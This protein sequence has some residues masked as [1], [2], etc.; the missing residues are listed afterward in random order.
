MNTMRFTRI[1]LHNW[2]N[3]VRVDVPLARRVLVIGP[4]AS[5]KSNFLDAFRFLR[6]LTLPSG[7]G[8]AAAVDGLRSG[9]GKLRS[10]HARGI[11]SDIMIRV[12]VR[13]DSGMGWFYELAFTQ[14]SGA[15]GVPM[16][17]REI[18]ARLTKEGRVDPPLLNRPDD[19]DKADRKRLIQ[20]AVEQVNANEK[21]RELNEFFASVSYLH[22]VPQLL[23]EGQAASPNRIGA[24][25]YG[26]DLLDRMGDTSRKTREARLRR[27]RDVLKAVT[28]DLEELTLERDERGRPHLSA[29]VR[30]WRP[31]GAYQD[32]TQLSD[33]TLRL[34]GLLWALQEKAGTLLLEEP[35]LSLH[36]AIV[37]KLAPF[38]AKAQRTGH[39]RQVILSTHSE[40]LLLDP[41]IAAEE[42]LLVRPVKEGS[43]IVTGPELHNVV[44]LMQAGIP[45]AEAVLPFTEI[46]QMELFAQSSA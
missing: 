3:F 16:V 33:G 40:N 10:L 29:K 27:I 46:K 14:Q 41:G 37:R 25:Q 35:E 5:G 42:I 20:T 26:R 44:D 22:L 23:R 18:V 15:R 9:V 2:K 11:N 21:F 30:Q 36:Y 19:H 43:E 13:D 31:T 1:E 7:G 39:G 17:R 34:I 4:N 12:E 6:D 24:D 8:L 28:A 45:A 38:I 32:E